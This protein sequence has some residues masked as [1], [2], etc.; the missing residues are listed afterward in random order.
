MWGVKKCKCA[1]SFNLKNFKKN[2]VTLFLH[3]H[4]T[5]QGTCKKMFVGKRYVQCTYCSNNRGVDPTKMCNKSALYFA[6]KKC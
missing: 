3:K 4:F 5:E 1:D 6:P 2:D